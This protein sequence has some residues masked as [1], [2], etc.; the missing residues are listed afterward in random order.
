MIE[1]TITAWHKLIETK[2]S[3]GLD[4]ILDEYWFSLE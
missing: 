3:T 2:D 1:N 4:N